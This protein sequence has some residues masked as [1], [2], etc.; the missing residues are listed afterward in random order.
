VNTNLARSPKEFDGDRVVEM[1]TP[2]FYLSQINLYIE[3]TT[4]KQS[5]V[6]KKNRKLRLIR[7]L[8]PEIRFRLL[9]RRDF[10]RLLAKFGFG[11]LTSSDTP[12]A[13]ASP[14]VPVA[15]ASPAVPGAPGYRPRSPLGPAGPASP[16]QAANAKTASA[17]CMAIT[18]FEYRSG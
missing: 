10:H 13:S 12:V 14:A 17:A 16:A 3:L 9:Y 5:L 11:P 18:C 15:P 4:L 2:G 1:F 6:T 7:E 8:N